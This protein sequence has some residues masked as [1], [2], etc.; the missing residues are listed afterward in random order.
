MLK[1]FL[2]PA[3]KLMISNG[4]QGY[5]PVVETFRAVLQHLTFGIEGCTVH[6]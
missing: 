6:M 2:Q 5:S 1:L 4:L 3:T